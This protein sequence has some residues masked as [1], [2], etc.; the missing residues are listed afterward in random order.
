LQLSN[1]WVENFKVWPGGAVYAAT[2]FAVRALSEGLRQE[3][4]PY[5]IR[6]TVISPGAVATELLSPSLMWRRPSARGPPRLPFLPSRSR[7]RSSSPYVG[8][9]IGLLSLIAP[10]TKTGL[11]ALADCTAFA[12]SIGQIALFASEPP[13]W[14]MAILETINNV[15]TWRSARNCAQSMLKWYD[16]LQSVNI[17][18]PVPQAKSDEKL[19]D[20]KAV[21][22]TASREPVP[23]AKS[24]EKTVDHKA[25][26]DSALNQALD[27]FDNVLEHP[28]QIAPAPNNGV[29]DKVQQGLQKSPTA[30]P[31]SGGDT[32]TGVD[33]NGNVIIYQQHR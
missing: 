6:M 28:A 1:N 25:L 30:N 23:Q 22:D 3:V 24:D 21:Q 18:E 5:N 2:K 26:Q 8:E 17:R 31:S 29:L 11:A 14:P 16:H 27:Q 32:A 4:K 15:G 12:F 19:V 33:K 20:T 10:P 9:E 7:G 13:G